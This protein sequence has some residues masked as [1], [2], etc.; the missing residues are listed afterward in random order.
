MS[1]VTLYDGQERR[2]EVDE[3]ERD[4]ESL[5]SGGRRQEFKVLG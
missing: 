2:D 4:A 5:L 3:L 1:S